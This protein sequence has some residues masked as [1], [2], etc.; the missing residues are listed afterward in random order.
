MKPQ[1]TEWRWR[2]VLYNATYRVRYGVRTHEM[3]RMGQQ[4]VQMPVVCPGR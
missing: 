4:L 3:V 1:R 2:D